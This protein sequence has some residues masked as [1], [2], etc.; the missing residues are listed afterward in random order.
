MLL[1]GRG[2]DRARANI[3]DPATRVLGF[4][5][6]ATAWRH[7]CEFRLQ[8]ASDALASRPQQKVFSFKSLNLGHRCP[9]LGAAA[10]DLYPYR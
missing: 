8:G 4:G 3:Q 7:G 10:L 2:V 5:V 6:P 9:I 1:F